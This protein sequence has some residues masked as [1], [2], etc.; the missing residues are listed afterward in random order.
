MEYNKSEEEESC[1]RLFVYG[2]LQHNQ[3]RGYVLKELK[4]QP[5]ILNG[6]RKITPLNLGFPFIIQEKNSN[7]QGEIYYDLDESLWRQIDLIEGEGT[8]YERIIVK[9]TTKDGKE[10]NAYTFYPSKTLI[11]S[12][13]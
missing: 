10:L 1:N 12:Y 11:D 5:A 13:L 6:Y 3:S 8:L 2:T 4:F 9:V 7:V